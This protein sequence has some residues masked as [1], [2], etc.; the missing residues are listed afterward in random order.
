MSSLD[1]LCRLRSLDHLGSLSPVKPFNIFIP[2]PDRGLGPGHEP[3]IRDDCADEAEDD[4]D[5]QNDVHGDR[6]LLVWL[7][8]FRLATEVSGGC[9]LRW[10]G[11]GVG[12]EGALGRED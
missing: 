2:F 1:F 9:G 3:A 8:S 5:A 11:G 4:K 10:K 12:R 7:E 6:A